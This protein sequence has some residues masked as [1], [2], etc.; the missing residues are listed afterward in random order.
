[1]TNPNWW[2]AQSL[3][4]FSH[5]VYEAEAVKAGWKTQEQCRVPF[6]ELPEANKTVMLAVASA[7][8]A[9]VE[10]RGETSVT[11]DGSGEV[12]IDWYKC[13]ACEIADIMMGSNFCPHCGAR[14]SWDK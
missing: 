3:A 13:G 1:M 7:I 5:D 12:C 2:D 14:I 8:I 9:E 11:Q 10:K 6:D 4:A